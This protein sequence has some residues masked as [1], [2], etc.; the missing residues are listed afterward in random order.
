MPILVVDPEALLELVWQGGR[1]GFDPSL[2]TISSAT[3]RVG[4][5]PWCD[6]REAERG[7]DLGDQTVES[8]RD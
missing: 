7:F 8:V 2:G 3:A 5:C 4:S 6:S 1:T